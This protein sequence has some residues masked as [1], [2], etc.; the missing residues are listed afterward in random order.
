[1]KNPMAYLCAQRESG[2]KKWP[3]FYFFPDDFGV[4]EPLVISENISG[5]KWCLYRSTRHVN[6]P[7]PTF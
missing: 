7:T 4:K 2:E 3:I 5:E 1:M 6:G